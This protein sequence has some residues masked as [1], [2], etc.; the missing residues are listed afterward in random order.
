MPLKD[1][2]LT[3]MVEKMAETVAAIL[4]LNR[5]G[6]VAGAREL[7]DQA[8]R[9]Q[10]GSEA[11]LLHLLPSEQLLDLLSSAGALDVE[12]TL[13]IAELLQLDGDVRAEAGESAP[14]PLALKSLDLSV[15]ALLAAPDLLVRLADKVDGRI[16]TLSGYALPPATQRRLFEYY[17]LAGQYA[18][19]EDQLFELLEV[20]PTGELVAR[21]R[22]FYHALGGL[23]DEALAAGGL[24]R[25]EL[26]EG[27]HSLERYETP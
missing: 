14:S 8:Y 4:T 20:A 26:E 5:Q 23:S 2:F 11:Q 17:A 22:R 24:P 25:A 18:R 6:D 1:D 3:R 9:E 7:L 12:K 10:T 27:M 19:A 21:G 13:I 16:G 15:E